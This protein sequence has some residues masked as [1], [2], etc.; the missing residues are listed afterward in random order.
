MAI[1]IDQVKSILDLAWCREGMEKTELNSNGW[2]VV[3]V[4][5]AQDE[6]EF[7]E[8]LLRQGYREFGDALGWRDRSG[9]VPQ[10]WMVGADADGDVCFYRQIDESFDSFAP[11]HP[12]WADC[13]RRFQRLQARLQ[14]LDYA[15]Q[16]ARLRARTLC[17]GTVPDD[18]TLPQTVWAGWLNALRG[19]EQ[20][21][22]QRGW[23]VEPLALMAP[24]TA[25]QL[26][27][28]EARHGV[29]IPAQLRALLQE[30]S[31]EFQFGWRC[32]RNDEPKGRLK[33][34]YGGGIRNMVWS[35]EMID[36]Q[37]LG[38][39]ERWRAYFFGPDGRG[40]DD[41]EQPNPA[42]LWD[43]QF[44][45]ADLSNGDILT[46]DTR[47]A[48]PLEQPVRYFS[49]EVEGLHGQVLAPNLYAFLDHWT[50]LGCAGDEQHSWMILVTEQGLRADTHWGR[51]WTE[52]LAQDQF[53]CGPDEA[54]RAL[55]ARSAAD[56]Q[57]LASAKADD[58]AGVQ[59]ALDQG[60]QVNCSPDDWKDENYTAVIFAVC[61]KSIAMLQLLKARGASLATTLLPMQV[62]AWNSN[63]ETAQWLIANGARLEPWRDDGSGGPLHRLIGSDYSVEDFRT[64]LDRLLSAGANPD[65]RSNSESFAAGKTAL[66]RVGPWSTVR[67]LAAGA[68]ATLRDAAGRTALHHVRHVE[69]VALLLAQGLDVNDRAGAAGG[70]GPTPLQCALRRSDDPIDI[71]NALL[72]AGADPR[73]ADGSGHDAWWYCVHASCTNRLVDLGFD[74][75]ARDA[76]G[77]TLLHRFLASNHGRL[78][79]HYMDCTRALLQAGLPVDAPDA[80]GN[81]ALHVA[82]SHCS[83]EHD[84]PTLKFLLEQGASRTATNVAGKTAWDMLAKKHRK[85]V[86]WLRA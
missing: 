67:L 70:Q 7:H 59:A 76:Q 52:W 28:V 44:A 64:I 57:L 26:V 81:T 75:A 85:A 77:R 47:N 40:E 31:A 56:Q 86:G 65:V 60:A 21:A 20:T 33:S 8:I 9:P 25:A 45:F 41:Y 68:D 43:G 83:S 46:I 12:D 74:P 53:A 3:P 82:A 78:Y 19:M 63:V 4:P 16:A 80:D 24:A 51:K 72:A 1:G 48:D 35:L 55:L 6:A 11:A 36:Q 66:M 54:P 14:Q 71:V 42:S 37:A 17:E 84:H 27:A 79:D 32:A 49:H 2:F 61:N 69:S 18:V 39:F 38:N 23:T 30:L 29:R 10:T 34:L 50:A 73:L 62:A 15:L 13:V 58:L 22:S 5:H